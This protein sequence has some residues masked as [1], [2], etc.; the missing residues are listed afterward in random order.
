MHIASPGLY[1]VI[2]KVEAREIL[3]AN[4]QAYLD[5][6][7]HKNRRRYERQVVFEEHYAEQ[8]EHADQYPCESCL[9]ALIDQEHGTDRCLGAGETL[10]IGLSYKF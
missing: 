7:A 1:P 8:G 9:G 5:E 6:Y 3:V 4:I 2:P 10:G